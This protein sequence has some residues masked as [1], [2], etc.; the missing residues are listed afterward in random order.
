[1]CQ[2]Q[3]SRRPTNAEATLPPPATAR[4]L[5]PTLDTAE[6][7]A[8]SPLGG[9]GLGEVPV[10]PSS[11]LAPAPR[12]QQPKMVEAN[13]G[14]VVVEIAKRAGGLLRRDEPAPVP[15]PPLHAPESG[16]KR[17]ASP[18]TPTNPR[19]VPPIPAPSP[20]PPPE[21]PRLP[22]TPDKPPELPKTEGF[23]PPDLKD[24]LKSVPGGGFTIPPGGPIALPGT[25]PDDIPGILVVTAEM[26]HGEQKGGVVGKVSHVEEADL[27]AADPTFGRFKKLAERAAEIVGPGKG[28]ERGKRIHKEVEKLIETEFTEEERTNI[29]VEYTAGQDRAGRRGE[30]GSPRVDI[31]RDMGNG[32]A[33]IYELKTGSAREKATRVYRLFNDTFFGKITR[34]TVT[35]I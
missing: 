12:Q 17:D 24:I 3:T 15:P 26:L 9:P 13:L 2:F 7:P 11:P 27:A 4:A 22:P 18:F 34:A 14:K 19:D 1:M 21:P 30:K 33:R 25:L 29:K 10:Q 20:T 35:E 31:Y 23:V 28:P 5:Y 8:V 16:Q 32:E 6:A